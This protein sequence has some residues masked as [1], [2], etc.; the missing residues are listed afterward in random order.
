MV[1]IWHT[2][3]GIAA[4]TS[5]TNVIDFALIQTQCSSLS[6][7]WLFGRP[8][9]QQT[10]QQNRPYSTSNFSQT[11]H[12]WRPTRPPNTHRTVH[13]DVVI[14]MHHQ[15]YAQTDRI[16]QN[17]R[18]SICTSTNTTHKYTHTL[19]SAANS[20]LNHKTHSLNGQTDG[21]ISKC[22][23]MKLAS[24]FYAF[25]DRRQCVCVSVEFT[26]CVCCAF[27][28]VQIM[29]YEYAQWDKYILKTELGNRLWIFQVHFGFFFY[30]SQTLKHFEIQ[31]N[32]ML[33]SR[34]E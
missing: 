8:A 3:T 32:S 28:H 21:W 29:W 14:I 1:N 24:V 27:V 34:I 25:N 15:T 31:W 22:I 5:V 2:N 16:V 20:P 11:P 13:V 9:P 4:R 26:R 33:Y 10:P 17:N 23:V 18:T 6:N 12:N 7:K 19:N 30:V